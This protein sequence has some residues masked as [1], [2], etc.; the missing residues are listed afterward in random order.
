MKIKLSPARELDFEGSGGFWKDQKAVKNYIKFVLDTDF[1][2]KSLLKTIFW[3]FEALSGLFW[4]PLERCWVDLGHPGGS[5][6]GS[7]IE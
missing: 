4:V 1:C 2:N 7:K 3:D 5:K 6:K